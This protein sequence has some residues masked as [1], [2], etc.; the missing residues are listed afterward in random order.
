LNSTSG[1]VYRTQSKEVRSPTYY[2][3]DI[4]ETYLKALDIS[5]VAGNNFSEQPEQNKD[6]ILINEDAL[7][8]LGFTSAEEAIGTKIY[9]GNDYRPEIVGVV[10]NY[11]HLSL[12][13]SIIPLVFFYQQFKGSYFTVR[14]SGTSRQRDVIAELQ[15]LWKESFG[16]NV[17]EHFY[18]DQ[19]FNAQYAADK[20]F[21]RMFTVFTLLAVF[22]A[23]LGL[24]GLSA[25]AVVQR[26]KEIGIRKVLGASI[27]EIIRTLSADFMKLILLAIFIAGVC[28]YWVIN[29]WLSS[30]AF[31]IDLS[32]WIMAIP[33]ALLLMIAIATIGYHTV[34]AASANPVDALKSE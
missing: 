9:W 24:L 26:T 6:K 5:L 33:A 2:I 25:Y 8:K 19:R 14:L 4:N 18:L 21:S 34:K 15:Q 7:D 32:W 16:A 12:D 20:Q 28:S 1:S 29:S 31:R 10:K 11:H 13:E 27:A 23:C 3:Y 22:I 30:Y 17:F